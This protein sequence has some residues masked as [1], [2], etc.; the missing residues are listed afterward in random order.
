MQLEVTKSVSSLLILQVIFVV[1]MV[2]HLIGYISLPLLETKSTCVEVPLYGGIQFCETS[3]KRGSYS[4]NLSIPFTDAEVIVNGNFIEFNST[5]KGTFVVVKA[6]KYKK[7]LN[8]LNDKQ[9][10]KYLNMSAVKKVGQYSWNMQSPKY[11]APLQLNH[12]E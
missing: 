3:I 12:I 4:Q 2:S 7:N 6:L 9:V 11:K 1:A 5:S 10:E 8:Q